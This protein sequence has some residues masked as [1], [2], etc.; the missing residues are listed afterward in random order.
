MLIVHWGQREEDYGGKAMEGEG[1]A[2]DA[3]KTYLMADLIYAV[4]QN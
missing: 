1:K 2:K 4:V 3:S